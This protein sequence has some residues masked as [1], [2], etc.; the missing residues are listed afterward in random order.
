MGALLVLSAGLA[1]WLMLPSRALS[2]TERR[3]QNRDRIAIDTAWQRYYREYLS[4]AEDMIK[5]FLSRSDDIGKEAVELQRHINALRKADE[6]ASALG[7]RNL[8]PADCPL[9]AEIE[10]LVSQFPKLPRRISD[11]VAVWKE[12]ANGCREAPGCR[13]EILAPLIQEV[14]D[15]INQHRCTQAG[16][17]QSI[18]ASQCPDNKEVAALKEEVGACQEVK[19]PPRPIP[20]STPPRPTTEPP[21]PAGTPESTKKEKYN[22]LCNEATQALIDDHLELAQTKIAEA[23]EIYPGDYRAEQI[24][25]TIEAKI[26][27]QRSTVPP[28]PP[29]PGK[30]HAAEALKLGID[31]YH[32]GEYPAAQKHIRE[33]LAVNN[34]PRLMALGHFFEGAMAAHEYLLEA[35]QNDAKKREALTH[36]LEAFQLWGILQPT[37]WKEI[38]AAVSPKV[39]ELY[40]QAIV[41]NK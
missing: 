4:A 3:V 24:R 1:F 17:K 14:R 26:A 10:S 32:R 9:I 22:K 7:K 19:P 35:G 31:A 41:T 2:F 29:T 12:R 15:L 21:I 37:E 30:A 13:P 8:S 36:F 27:R 23:L 40:T 28:P 6:K 16:E 34:A 38:S 11:N 20:P 5:P 18:L 39:L 33:F 25:K